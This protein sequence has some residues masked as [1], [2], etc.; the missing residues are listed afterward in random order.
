[1]PI[2]MSRRNGMPSSSSSSITSFSTIFA[3]RSSISV[4]IIGNMIRT[5]PSTLARMIARS[6]RLNIGM[7]CRHMRIERSPRN[8][9]RSGLAA[10]ACVYLSAP[11]SS[12]RMTSG[13]P[14]EPPERVGVGV[15]VLFLGRLVLAGEVEELGAVQPDALGAAVD[16][17]VDVLGELDVRLQADDV[18]VLRLGG[19]VGDRAE[20]GLELRRACCSSSRCSASCSASG[21]TITTP[22]VPSMMTMSPPLTSPVMLPSPTTAGMPIARATIAVWLVRPPTSVA[23]PLHVQLGPG[24]R[25][26]WAAGRGR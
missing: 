22:R 5:S 6:C 3:C 8:G 9:L 17:V 7:S 13:L 19:Q 20:L 25:S 24:R 11:R 15:V 10:L 2:G 14:L 23:K 26:G 1:M 16:G 4:Q 21:L 12:V 18:P